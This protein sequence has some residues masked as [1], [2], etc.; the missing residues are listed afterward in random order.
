MVLAVWVSAESQLTATSR[1]E[2]F[3]SE[4]NL[5]LIKPPAL[6]LVE[7]FAAPLLPQ[8]LKHFGLEA[9]TGQ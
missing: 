6:H 4:E 3:S 1:V 7:E 8:F 9:A 2:I 5:A